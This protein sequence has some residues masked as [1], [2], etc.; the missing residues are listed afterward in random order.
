MSEAVF[1]QPDLHGVRVLPPTRREPARKWL[2]VLL[3]LAGLLIVPGPVEPRLL[4]FGLL[5]AVAWFLPDRRA[6]ALDLG[7]DTLSLEWT[8]LGRPERLVARWDAVSFEVQRD[9]TRVLTLRLADRTVPIVWDGTQD[10]LD[11]LV[12]LL[13]Q[14]KE[15]YAPDEPPEPPESLQRL[16]AKELQPVQ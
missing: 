13:D 5:A 16:R 11:E 1:Q 2:G 3:G 14:A 12:T 6:T 8:R 10:S 4:A 7:P 15:R 9:P